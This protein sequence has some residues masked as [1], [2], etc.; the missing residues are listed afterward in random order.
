METED[1]LHTLGPEIE[2]VD[3]ETFDIFSQDRQL[4]G[5]GMLDPKASEI[6]ITVAGR[7]FTIKQSPGILNSSSDSG[8]TGAVLWKT[9]VAFANWMVQPKNILM[10]LGFFHVNKTII[11]L[12]CGSSGILPHILAPRVQEY[13]ATDQQHILKTLKTNLDSHV[14]AQPNKMRKA[15]NI[16]VLAL[17]W[18]N[19]DVSLT[20]TSYGHASGADTIVACDCIYNY[21]LIEPFMQTCAEICRVRR[22]HDEAGHLQPTVCVVAQHLRQPDVFEK[23]LERFIRDFRVWR[24][25]ADLLSTELGEGSEFVVHLAILR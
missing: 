20:L 19:S 25:T 22:A 24:I 7:D 9:S 5:L 6:D 21:A 13:V 11:E 8:T 10:Q 12:G 4:D 18:E 1:L 15:D 14:A 3:E 16:R 2:D 23:W 17:D